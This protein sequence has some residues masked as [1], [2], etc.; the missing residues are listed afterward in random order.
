MEEYISVIF[1]ALFEGKVLR[2]PIHCNFHII[3]TWNNK[4]GFCQ[5]HVQCSLLKMLAYIKNI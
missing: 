3:C 2:Q 1:N 4:Y 5:L